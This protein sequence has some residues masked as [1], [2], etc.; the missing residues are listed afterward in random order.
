[1]EAAQL[2]SPLIA[3]IEEK[4]ESGYEEDPKEDQKEEIPTPFKEEKWQQLCGHYPQVQPFNS[5]KRFL[6]IR[7]EDFI[8]LQEQYQKLVQNSFLLHGYYNYG[9]M[10]L[11]K[12]EEGKE[13]PY[14]IGVPGVF[15]EKERQAAGLFGFAGFEGVEL[16][17]KN[18]SYGY[19]MI[20]VKL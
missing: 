17:V 8:I 6:S 11:G 2:S 13:A 15:Y 9:H 19:Y 3:G 10:I 1:M 16:P 7:P 12:L 5:G 18:G 20:E 14:Y 4:Y